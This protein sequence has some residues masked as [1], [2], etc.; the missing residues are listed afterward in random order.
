M[1]AGSRWRPSTGLAGGEDAL[2]QRAVLTAFV[3]V[4]AVGSLQAQRPTFRAGVDLVTFGVTV[5][6]RQGQLV[7]DLAPDDFEIREDGV[8]QS[9]EYFARGDEADELGG[10][11]LGLMLDLSGSMARNLEMSRSAAIRFLNTLP[12]ARDITLVDFDTEVR[13][14][15]YGQADFPRLVERIRHG[16]LGEWTAF[17]DA[18]GLYLDGV[19]QLDGRKVLVMYTD[20]VDTR[21]ALRFNETM[22]LVKAAGVTIYAVGF[23]QRRASVSRMEGRLRLTQIAEAT[24]GQAYFPSALTD[25]DETYARVLAEIR[26]QYH[27][28]YVSTNRVADGTWR[29]VEVRLKRPDLRVRTREGYFAPYLEPPGG[30]WR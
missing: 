27:L 16:S 8:P 1:T 11:R 2:S 30:A 29:Q 7:T 10:M 14:S 22:T 15:R 3:A 25:L 12:E 17:H 6:D 13:V 21:S 19:D 4:L 9:L 18:L 23:V 28:G 24:G 5:V 20:G 26:G